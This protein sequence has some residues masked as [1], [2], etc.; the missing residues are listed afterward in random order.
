MRPD[1][2]IRVWA[3]ST[4]ADHVALIWACRSNEY[5][6]PRSYRA[7]ATGSMAASLPDLNPTGVFEQGRA[8][9]AQ[10][11]A[12]VP[13]AHDER[14]VPA[15]ARAN[16]DRVR[17]EATRPSATSTTTAS[18]P[19][20]GSRQAGRL[21]EVEKRLQGL[22]AQHHTACILVLLRAMPICWK[23]GW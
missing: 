12:S 16:R 8:E 23:R 20:V 5:L 1:D 13:G 15:R 2:S 7:F 14:G 6:D 17:A 21:S 4:R 9:C 11:E 18:R 19:R 10:T 22:Q 3:K